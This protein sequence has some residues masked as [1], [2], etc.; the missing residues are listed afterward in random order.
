VQ[1]ISLSLLLFMICLSSSAGFHEKNKPFGHN[2]SHTDYFPEKTCSAGLQVVACGAETWAI[3]T[4]PF[5]IG[6]YNMANVYFIKRLDREITGNKKT[7]Q[8]AYFDT[9]NE[10]DNISTVNPAFR[11]NST[12]QQKSVMAYYIYS[13]DIRDNYRLHWNTSISYFFDEK[14]PFS[15]RR[16]TFYRRKYQLNLTTLHE[17]KMTEYMGIQGELGMIHLEDRYPRLHTGASLFFKSKHWLVQFGFTLTGTLDGLFVSP[18]QPTRADYQQELR[19]RT[20]GYNGPFDKDKI[21]EDFSMHPEVAI[22][23]LF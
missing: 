10:T 15:I 7:I 17:V 19:S 12:Y 11:L 3:G 21:K 1:E 6:I 8:L 22:Q 4:S 5:L 13:Q 14:Y 2:I 20:S 23:Y 16:P 18:D 9:F